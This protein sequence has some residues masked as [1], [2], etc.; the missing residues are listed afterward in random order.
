[1]KQYERIRILKFYN[2]QWINGSGQQTLKT[3]NF[4]KKEKPDI[5][6]TYRKV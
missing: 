3:G 5:M 6:C 2:P 4:T 1:M